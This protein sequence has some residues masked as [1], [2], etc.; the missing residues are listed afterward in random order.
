M[1]PQTWLGKR[2]NKDTAVTSD[3][4]VVSPRHDMVELNKL[5]K[6]EVILYAKKHNIAINSRRKKE[7]IINIIGRS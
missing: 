1:A 5:T 4:L 7:E 2:I 3:P 6:R